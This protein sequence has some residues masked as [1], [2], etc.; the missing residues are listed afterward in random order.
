MLIILNWYNLNK[1]VSMHKLQENFQI[2]F[3]QVNILEV[4]T[5]KKTIVCKQQNPL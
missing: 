2:Y 1:I 3:G 4:N 5:L